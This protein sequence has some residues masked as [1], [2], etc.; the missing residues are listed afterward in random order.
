MIDLIIFFHIFLLS[1]DRKTFKFVDRENLV[2]LSS[3][4]NF[5]V[6]K[7]GICIKYKNN[8]RRFVIKNSKKIIIDFTG[9]Y[10]KVYRRATDFYYLFKFD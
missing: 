10:E 7:L 2:F 4:D 3:D 6:Y 1:K 8:K 5:N 9:Y